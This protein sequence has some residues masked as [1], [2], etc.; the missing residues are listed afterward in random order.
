M[1]DWWQGLEER[2]R[3]IVAIGGLLLSLVLLF[4]GVLDPLQRSLASASA[5]QSGKSKVFR[6]LEAIAAQAGTLRAQQIASGTLPPELTLQRAVDETAQAS[7]L[8]ESISSL[9]PEKANLKV[10]MNDAP[11]TPTLMWLMTLRQEYGIRVVE[12]DSTRGSSQGTANL[13]ITLTGR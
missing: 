11:L 13:S 9:T 2:E 5:E 4:L 3:R 1:N 7:S 8:R 12:L 6:E 10:L